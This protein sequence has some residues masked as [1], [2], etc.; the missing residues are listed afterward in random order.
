MKRLALAWLCA[1]LMGAPVPLLAQEVPTPKDLPST[2][3]AVDWI[4]KDPSV[5]EARSA[6]AAAGRA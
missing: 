1:T 6:L 5:V 2:E 4:D 3:Q